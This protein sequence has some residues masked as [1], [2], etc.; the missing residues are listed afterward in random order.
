MGWRNVIITQHAKLTYS[1]N[2]MIVQT[3]DGINQI[4]LDDINLLLVST[5]QA[6]ITSALISQL[7]Q[8]QIKV[9]FVDDQYQPVCE[10]VDYYPHSRS[11]NCLID[12]F[13][14]P[15]DRKD[16]LWTAIIAAK[17]QN[18]INVL[19]NYSLHNDKVAQCLDQLELDDATNREAYAAREYFMT[20]FDKNFVRKNSDVI[21][22]ALNYGYSFL[23]STVNREIEING[24]LSYL[25]IHHCS[26]ENQFNLASDF[27]EPFRPLVD[28]WVK[29]HEKITDFTPDI[30]YGLVELLSLKIEFN[31]KKILLTN[32]LTEYVR[33][34]LRYLNGELQNYEMK[35]GLTNEVPNDALN[36][37]V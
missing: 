36:D 10:T 21:N 27:M 3:K 19:N 11:M 25:G 37:N 20:L 7:A 34:C 24:Y 1:M 23:L 12:Q 33:N 30:K 31:G 17:I 18:Q 9:I 35:V 16:K 8:R 14:W 26:Q 6:V 5:T 15:Q 4:P 32:A 2:M 28:Y 22:A 13:N 29:D